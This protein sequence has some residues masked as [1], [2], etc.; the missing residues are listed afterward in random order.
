MDLDSWRT[1]LMHMLNAN[2]EPIELQPLE[3]EVVRNRATRAVTVRAAVDTERDPVNAAGLVA[4]ACRTH[5]N[6]GLR[7]GKAAAPE[8]PEGPPPVAFREADSGL[9]H[10]IYR[11]ITVRFKYGTSQ[12]TRSDIL[13]KYDLKVR[14]VNSYVDDQAIVY[15]PERKYSGERLLEI[16]N[17]IS[18]MDEV[19]F[20]A[21]N[22]V[23]QFQRHVAPS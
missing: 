21:P 20:A 13:K 23:S 15:Q 19:T 1:S 7:E 10:V 14:D 16:S 6:I 2:K 11:E 18:E 12:K 9:L 22:F 8:A 4:R 5:F 3:T 17:D